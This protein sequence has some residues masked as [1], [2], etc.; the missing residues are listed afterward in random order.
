M[1]RESDLH[2]PVRGCGRIDV[3]VYVSRAGR[4]WTD[5]GTDRQE[6]GSLVPELS[7]PSSTAAACARTSNPAGRGL[8][9]PGPPARFG[10][11]LTFRISRECRSAAPCRR[12]NWGWCRP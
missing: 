4:S 2:L 7:P 1:L 3:S 6:R 8:L 10:Q 5:N 9:L 12:E 11:R